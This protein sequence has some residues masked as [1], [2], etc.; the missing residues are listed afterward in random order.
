MCVFVLARRG[1][2]KFKDVNFIHRSGYPWISDPPNYRGLILLMDFM[3]Q[4][5]T[6]SWVGNR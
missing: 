4:I 1:G 2:V 5:S 6:N 3:G